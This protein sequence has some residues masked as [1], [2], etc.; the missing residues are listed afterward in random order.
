MNEE[1]GATLRLLYQLKIALERHL[2]KG[3]LT[4]TNLKQKVVDNKVKKV[5]DLAISLPKIHTQYGVEEP[6][7]KF[8]HKPLKYVEEK[9]L[10]YEVARANLEK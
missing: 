1:R 4:V 5:A 8:K 7:F 9:L 10:K 3:D 2:A 6:T